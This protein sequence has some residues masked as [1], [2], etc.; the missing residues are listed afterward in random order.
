MFHPFGCSVTQ[1]RPLS[2]APPRISTPSRPY[3]VNPVHTGSLAFFVSQRPPALPTRVSTEG[4]ASISRWPQTNSYRYPCR[5]TEP[6]NRCSQ[7]GQEGRMPSSD[8]PGLPRT[9]YT[10]PFN[11][12]HIIDVLKQQV[13]GR[14]TF[15]V[16]DS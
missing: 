14:K 16:H 9:G 3:Y 10:S 5:A 4:L 6:T 8:G 7:V 15:E 13:A 1:Q 12:D 2:A 11:H